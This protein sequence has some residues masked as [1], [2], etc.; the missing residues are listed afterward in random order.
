MKLFNPHTS[1][2][3]KIFMI[4]GLV[5]FFGVILGGIGWIVYKSFPHPDKVDYNCIDFASQNDA[6][7]YF[8]GQGGSKTNNVDNLDED[9]NGIACEALPHHNLPKVS[10]DDY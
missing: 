9:S 10:P 6:Q 7:N 3:E 2:E 1:K 4:C 8:A 5:F